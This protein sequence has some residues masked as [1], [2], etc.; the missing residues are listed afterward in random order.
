MIL[1]SR[2]FERSCDKLN[3]SN[4]RLHLNNGHQTW[5][6]GDLT[7]GVF[8]HKFIYSGHVRSHDK[9][10]YFHYCNIYCHKILQ[11]SAIPWG[12]PVQKFAWSLSKVV[13]WGQ[14]TKYIYYLFTFK[15]LMYVIN[16]KWR[17][18]LKNSYLN[19]QKTY[20]H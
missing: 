14:V 9:L 17:D 11:G 6:G 10:T 3:T 2:R 15:R 20:G 4:L 12:A 8:N 1:Q 18:N 16:V 5:H 19:L 13:L 7:W